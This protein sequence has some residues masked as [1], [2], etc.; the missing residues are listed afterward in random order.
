MAAPRKRYS[1]Y[2]RPLP[3]LADPPRRQPV[4]TD[5]NRQQQALIETLLAQAYDALLVP[6]VYA[7]VRLTFT[8]QDGKIQREIYTDR[9]EQHRLAE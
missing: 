5:V 3:H 4:D 9:R 1:A 7:E 2:A 8:I 6:G